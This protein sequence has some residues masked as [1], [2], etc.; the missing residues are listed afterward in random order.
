MHSTNW[1]RHIP[2][3]DALGQVKLPVGQVDLSKVFFYELYKL[4]EKNCMILE[5]G[6]VI[7]SLCQVLTKKWNQLNF[8]NILL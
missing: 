3:L 1:A 6:S 7:F 2:L 8:M 4:T 5:V